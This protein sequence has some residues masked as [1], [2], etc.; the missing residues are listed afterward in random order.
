MKKLQR[1][2]KSNLT[3]YTYLF[4]SSTSAAA[5]HAYWK[6]ELARIPALHNWI[7]AVWWL[8]ELFYPLLFPF[9]FFVAS[10]ITFKPSLSKFNNFILISLN[11]LL[12]GMLLLHAGTA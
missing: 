3:S 1:Y 5:Y 6:Y 11:V 7:E 4:F 9:G 10:L 2:F 8:I 12:F